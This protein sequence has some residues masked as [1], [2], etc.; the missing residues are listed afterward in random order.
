[1]KQYAHAEPPYPTSYALE[2]AL[3]GETPPDLQYLLKD[4]FEDITIFSNRTLEASAHKRADGKY[5]V[6]IDIEAHKF[7]SDP[8]GYETEVPINDWIDIGAFAK[9]EK[10]KKY[11]ET[12]HRERVHLTESK[13]THTFTV[14]TLP[15]QARVDPFPLLIHRIPADNLKKVT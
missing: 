9:P 11:G 15:D 4:L 12:L 6:T 2:D 14:A 3:R 7:K 13:S 8:K 1:M 10:N 5:D